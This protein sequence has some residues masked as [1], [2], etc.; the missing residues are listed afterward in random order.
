VNPVLPSAVADRQPLYS[1]RSL[2]QRTMR[3]RQPS[4]VLQSTH[5]VFRVLVRKHLRN[6]IGSAATGIVSFNP[7]I[8]SSCLP[9]P[10][11]ILRGRHILVLE[12]SVVV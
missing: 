7:C 5:M 4:E 6:V 9:Q 1:T 3:F 8:P 12:Q 11:H 2:D 10:S